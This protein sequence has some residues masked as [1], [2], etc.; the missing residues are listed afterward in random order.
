MNEEDN[1]KLIIRKCLT[2]K[3]IKIFFEE[4]EDRR[5]F[6]DNN[7]EITS[8]QI[9][10]DDENGFLSNTAKRIYRI[11]CKIVHTKDSITYDEEKESIL[12]FSKK[13]QKLGYDIE[14][15]KFIA[16]KVLEH[17]SKPLEL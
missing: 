16:R 15:V 9:P 13:A 12:P 17:F 10:R 4:D 8:E 5:N 1:L 7:S 14:L 11:R 2:K 3:E 6:F